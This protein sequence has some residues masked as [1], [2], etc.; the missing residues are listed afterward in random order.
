MRQR[1]WMT[2]AAL[3][4]PVSPVPLVV[5]VLLSLTACSA[6]GPAICAS[7]GGTYAAGVC[8]RAGE[9][10]AEQQCQARG[11]VYLTGQDIC[12]VGAGGP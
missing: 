11:G 6:G 7:A 9:E 3:R 8:T 10:A 12:A 2:A 5:A 1:T 4:R